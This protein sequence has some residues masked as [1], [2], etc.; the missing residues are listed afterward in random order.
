M[1]K[2]ILR[3]NTKLKEFIEFA[4]SLKEMEEVKKN[5]FPIPT[6]ITYTLDK[7]N[8]ES[9]Q[10]EILVQKNMPLTDQYSD[11]F[12]LELYGITFKFLKK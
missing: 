12:E 1:S 9:I 6:S 3:N 4:Y 2:I 5:N 10:K 7:H 11:E 8:H